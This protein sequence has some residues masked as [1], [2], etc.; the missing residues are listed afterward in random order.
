MLTEI[1]IKKYLKEKIAT[2]III[3]HPT[4]EKAKNT[5][6]KLKEYLKNGNTKR[7]HN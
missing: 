4:E 7:K 5:F 1:L 3:C 6:K 2:K